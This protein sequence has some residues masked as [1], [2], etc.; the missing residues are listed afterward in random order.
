[1]SHLRVKHRRMVFVEHKIVYSSV[2]AILKFPL[3]IK[4]QGVEVV[5][6]LL[7]DWP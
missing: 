7:S 2:L 1:M 3:I 5:G 6:S 4:L